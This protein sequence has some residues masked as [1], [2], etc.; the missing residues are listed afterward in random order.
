MIIVTGAAG[1]LGHVVVEQLAKMIDPVRIGVSVRD[2]T[3]AA[4][5]ADRGI[6][7]RQGD[8]E[9]P[10]SLAD[11][12][13]GA[14]QVLIVSAN[15]LGDEA[16]RLHRTA[17]MAARAAGASRILYTSHQGARLGSPF[18]PADQHAGTE[19][20]LAEAGVPFT[21]IR[22]GFYAESCLLM[23]GDALRSGKLRVPED[24]PISWTA[25]AD[26][27]Q[28][29]AAILAG[30]TT[31]NGISPPL[32]S[33]VA[34]TMAELASIASE[35]TGR[36]IKHQ[37]ISD[38]EWRSTKVAAGMPEIYAD[39]LLG[40]FRAARRGDFASTHPSLGTILGRPPLTMREML[41]GADTSKH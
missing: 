6:R 12:F 36:E 41:A 14:E 27:A 25:R 35:V 8:F 1:Q 7:V 34:I 9:D 13:E 39:M 28:A 11:A 3:R 22:H 38:D 15:K 20:D 31:L 24:G 19:G 37:T 29:D 30:Q 26:L 5:L 23:V 16:R 4:T 32:T 18:A 21:S 10:A 2:P 33:G 40:T 17:V